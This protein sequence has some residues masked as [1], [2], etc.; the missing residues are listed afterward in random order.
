M[1]TK[2]EYIKE[3]VSILENINLNVDLDLSIIIDDIKSLSDD[4]Y[5]KILSGE[6]TIQMPDPEYD[7]VLDFCNKYGISEEEFDN[8]SIEECNE[9]V[10]NNKLK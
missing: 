3:Q 6:K 1:Q 8:M 7:R 4:E 9:L 5:E 10:R 2:E